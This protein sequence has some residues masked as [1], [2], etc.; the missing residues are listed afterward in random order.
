[1]ANPMG[2]SP[3]KDVFKMTA[4]EGLIWAQEHAGGVANG[5]QYPF[6][7]P[8][9]AWRNFHSS[10]QDK[11]WELVYKKGSYVSDL[12]ERNLKQAARIMELELEVSRLKGSL[13][14]SKWVGDE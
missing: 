10:W 3:T 13:A 14:T 4:E 1:M 9:F 11:Y 6:Y 7:T 12:R 2:R 8:P 5:T